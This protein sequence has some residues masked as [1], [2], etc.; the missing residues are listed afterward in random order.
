M[1]SSRRVIVIQTVSIVNPP[2]NNTPPHGGGLKRRGVE[3]G[4][5][6]SG[7]SAGAGVPPSSLQCRS[8]EEREVGVGWGWRGGGGGGEPGSSQRQGEVEGG[9]CPRCVQKNTPVPKYVSISCTFRRGE[10][11]VG[12]LIRSFCTRLAVYRFRRSVCRAV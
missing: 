3:A 6:P 12:A 1:F 8:D 9:K 5:Q 4:A 11:G 7:Q 2:S 10:G